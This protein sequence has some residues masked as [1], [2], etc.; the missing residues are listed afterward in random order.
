M[1]IRC[2]RRENQGS[3]KIL[4]KLFVECKHD[5]SQDTRDSRASVHFIW[6]IAS[7]FCLTS[8]CLVLIKGEPHKNAAAYKPFPPYIKVPRTLV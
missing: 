2:S 6:L 5:V 8:L 3:E 4:F 7:L 1:T